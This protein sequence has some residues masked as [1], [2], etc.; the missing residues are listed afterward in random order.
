MADF[1]IEIENSLCLLIVG[2]AGSRLMGGDCPSLVV[3]IR[4]TTTNV[5]VICV[6]TH[7]GS[8]FHEFCSWLGLGRVV[9]LLGV[10][11]KDISLMRYGNCGM[12]S[13]EIGD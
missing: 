13:A 10:H 7:L 2:I 6:T 12:K 1:V 8:L 11:G 3:W 4:R 9:I 5:R